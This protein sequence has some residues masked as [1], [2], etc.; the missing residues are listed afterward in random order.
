MTNYTLHPA[1][2][3]LSLNAS[4]RSWANSVWAANRTGPFSIATGNAAAWLPYPVVSS[5]SAEVARNLSSQNHAAYQPADTDATVVAGYRAQMAAYAAA[6]R[7][8]GTAF[9]N[10]V[11]TGGP[12]SGI[13]VM[14]H[15]L[16]RGTVNI[17]PAR[18]A[19]EPLVDYRALS[20]PLDAA[21]MAD[22]IRFN[23]RVFNTT[24]NR[25][26]APSEV[27]PGDSVASEDD[28]KAYL[29]Q[30]LSPSEFH[31]V[32]TCAMLPRE[33]GGVVDESLRVYGV[34]HLRIV[35]GSIMPTLPGANTCQTVYAVAEKVSI[36]GGRPWHSELT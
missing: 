34:K 13:L 23:R 20:N 26:F 31:P 1:D 5:R 8:N 18:P 30:T 16:S 17:D 25:G 4:F 24:A 7:S 35:D 33:L 2:S 21:I 22:L 29:A 14:L 32:G 11:F 12:N 10:S 28:L 36:C 3:D 9:Y 6:L 19:G 15:P 27:Q